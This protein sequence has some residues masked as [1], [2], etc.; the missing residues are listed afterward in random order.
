LVHLVRANTE[1]A[2][3]EE[4][5]ADEIALKSDMGKREAFLSCRGFI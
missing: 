3:R 5:I 4:C 2:C 1:A